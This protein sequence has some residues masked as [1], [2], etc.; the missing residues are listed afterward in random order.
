MD[1]VEA[2]TQVEG[3]GSER[4]LGMA[5]GDVCGKGRV[6][7]AHRWCRRPGW[8]HPFLA[9]LEDALPTVFRTRDRDWIGNR[10]ATAVDVIK[11][12]IGERDNDLA[13]AGLAWEGRQMP[14][15]LV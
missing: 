9:D 3:V 6:L 12:S 14:S 2:G 11:F 10:L 15:L 5:A 4:V 8:V 13:G 1:A 7:A